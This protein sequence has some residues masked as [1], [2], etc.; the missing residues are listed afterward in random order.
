MA[1]NATAIRDM[2]DTKWAGLNDTYAAAAKR[3]DIKE[4]LLQAIAETIVEQMPT[5][6]VT[7]SVPGVTAGGAT[8]AG[9]G[10]I[11]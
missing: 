2:I 1:L 6:T 3:Q 11:S 4:G 9:T 10:V 5:A 8:V 7:V